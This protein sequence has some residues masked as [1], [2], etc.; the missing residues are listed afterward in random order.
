MGIFANW[1]LSSLNDA[2]IPYLRPPVERLFDG[3]ADSRGLP[4]RQDFRDL[5][6]R[7]DMVDFKARELNKQVIELRAQ[8]QALRALNPG[9]RS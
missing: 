3:V 7:V 8:V 6:S 1:F 2:T 5:R 9:Q 4:S